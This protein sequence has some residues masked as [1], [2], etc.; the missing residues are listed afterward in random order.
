MNRH[1]TGQRS[2]LTGRAR[3]WIAGIATVAV[4][5]TVAVV[6]SGFDSRETPRAEPSVW[7]ARDA[8]QYAR[9]NTQT[10]EIDTVRKVSEPSGVV[11]RGADS[12]VLSHGNGQA[13]PVDAASPKDL[14]DDA[15]GVDETE[16]IPAPTGDETRAALPAV[17]GAEAAALPDGTRD[18]LG[19]GDHLL[20]RTESG[21]VYVGESV[22]SLQ[23]IDPLASGDTE[24][25]AFTADAAAIDA[26]GR[27]AVFSAGDATLWRYDA[28]AERF[29][30]SEEMLPESAAGIEQPELALVSG[31][32]V[33]L[34]P[35]KGRVFREGGAVQTVEFAG[36]PRLQW[37]GDG[38]GAGAGGGTAALI[39]DTSGLWRVPATGD[40]ERIVEA[41]GTPARP[42]FAERV[43]VAA[44]VD[45]TEGMLWR[46]GTDTASALTPL[47]FDAAAGSIGDP[48]PTFFTNGERTVL[49]EKRS[50]MLWTIPEGRLIPLSQWTISDPPKED[51]GTVVVEEVTE[52]VAPVAQDDAFGVRRGE[53]SQ[54][55][56]MLNDYD[57]NKRDVLTIVPE[58]LGESPLAAEFGTIELL[59]DAQSLMVRPAEGATGSATFSYRVT[60]GSLESQPAT[61]TLTVADDKVNTAPEWC[62][63]AGCQR[64]WAVPELAPGGTLVYPILEGWVDP[65]GD[66]MF[67][68]GVE[69]V[70]PEDPAR[71]MVTADGRLAVKHLD[72]NAGASEVMLRVLVR[73]ARGAEQ[74]RDLQVS[75]LPNALAR[76]TGVASTV[77][78]GE[79][80]ALDVLTRVSGGSGSF[81]VSDV[82]VVSGS[83]RVRAT[84][85]PAE[86]TV[87]ITAASP[88]QALLSVAV[89]D[90]G[91]GAELTGV[92]RI[93]A[94]PS[95][96]PLAL[97]PLRAFV[98]PSADSTV[99]ILNAIPG[100]SS[101]ALVVSSATVVDGQLRAEVIDHAKVRVAGSTADGGAGRIGAADIRVTEGDAQATG[102][103]TVFQVPESGQ[104]GAVAV[105][106]TATVRAGDVVDIRVLDNDVSAP[107][108][109]LVL[110]PEITGS[111]A[112]GELAFAS[113][114][115]LR[116]LA[117]EKAGTYQLSYTTY[118]ASSPES[119]DT[120]TVTVRVL[121]KGA[122]ADPVPRELTVRLAPGAVAEV[123]VPLS[124]VD[125][126]GDRVRLSGVTQGD[127]SHVAASITAGGNAIAVTASGE[128]EPGLHTVNYSVHDGFGGSGS[129]TLRVIIAEQLDTGAPVVSSD[130]V[131]V[132]LGATKPVVISPLD[133]DVDPA[134]GTLKILSV[135][136]NLPGGKAHPEYA[137]AAAR[138]DLSELTRGRIA[139]QAGPEPGTVSYKYTVQSRASSSTADGLILVQ[140]SDRV[141]TQAPAVTDTV[142]SVRDRADLAGSGV[143]VVTDK[144]RWAAGDV[145]AL[146]LSIW[147]GAKAGYQ[148]KG[149]RILGSYK[150]EGDLVPFKL[151][152]ADAAGTE[153]SSYGFLIV[154]PLDELRLTLRPG[155]EPLTVDENKSVDADVAA[156]VDTGAGDRVELRQGRFAVG[157]TGATCEATSIGRIRYTAG[158]EAPWSDVCVID[159]RLAGQS[160]WTSLPVPVTVV[161]RQPV[162]ALESLTRTVAPGASESIDLADMVRWEG[163]RTGDLSKLRFTVTGS[164]SQFTVTTS[165]ATVSVEAR[166]DA[167]PSNQQRLT[168]AVTGA[169][170]S[171]AP[172]VLRVGEV[173]RDTPRGA[174]VDL[175]CTVGSS[176]ATDV[177]GASGEYDPFAGKRGGGLK[178]DTVNAASCSV[179]NVRRAGD[180]GVAVSWPDNR[181][182][183]GQCTIG[184]TVRDAQG[185]TG[186]GSIELDAQGVPRSPASITATGATASSVT[187]TVAL[188]PQSA[189][190]AVS[191]VELVPSGGGGAGSCSVSGS[192]ATCTVN[193][194]T[195]G[196]ANQQ[197][198]FARAVN[199]VGASDQ[200]ANGAV[201]WAYAP[202]SA[203]T[204]EATPIRDKNNTSA[205]QGKVE[206]RISGSDAARRFLLRVD[207]A[208]PVEVGRKSVHVV[209][210]GKRNF[211]VIPEDPEMPP[212][213]AG[214][215]Q[216]AAGTASAVVGAAPQAGSA[217]IVPDS[218]GGGS[219]TVQFDGWGPNYASA[220]EYSFGLARD[221]AGR[222]RCSQASP[223]F[224]G[225]TRFAEYSGVMC[226]KS[227]FG[228]TTVQLGSVW[229]GGAPE[230]PSVSQGYLVAP[231]ASGSGRVR[232]YT[233]LVAQPEL[234]GTHGSARLYFSNG[235]VDA[236]STAPIGGGL[237]VKQ[238]VGDPS[239]GRC[240]AD[241]PVGPRDSGPTGVRIT[242]IGECVPATG[243]LAGLFQV[244]GTGPSAP[245]FTVDGQDLQLAW[246][247]TSWNPV[248]FTGAVCASP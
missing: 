69:M 238:C 56:V 173:P 64:E 103:L 163:N 81:T 223:E 157:R 89:T 194:L 85:R 230:A 237:T 188:N 106:D 46:S 58:S 23:L 128:A 187:L 126:D 201:T 229:V 142:M 21:R 75:V 213:Y 84:V 190:P 152:G 234:S 13:W 97:P 167:V 63:V 182:P 150:P 44:W 235:D 225:L 146:K 66:P 95:T 1:P 51:R 43:R 124:G 82:T 74:S 92:A 214:G 178:L 132:V 226:A 55:Q 172:L 37:S 20:V 233:R 137:R 86:G 8:G 67:L 208:A 195:P 61:V 123:R 33:L 127:D 34:D 121:P 189:H 164:S 154:P 243:D 62:P 204:V 48:E 108:E 5:V 156:L 236:L 101:R 210:P 52:Q 168:V 240:S 181:G 88:G 218:S 224:G 125:P 247:N 202:P 79:T 77:H 129:A 241:V 41:S 185:R 16:R 38:D 165:G 59:P 32:W 144:V 47:T 111:G 206:L 203:P 24:A 162:V 112:K 139:V 200:T 53:P 105:A 35:A 73:D 244:E 192:T 161:P 242:Q 149:G 91:T 221:G 215:S 42:S 148:V 104:G 3:G 228:S 71:A 158:A 175:R 90:V 115:T 180:R 141:G 9:V 40:P 36:S 27:V 130:Y 170:E 184:Y 17:E 232:E 147:E 183:G 186:E 143:D 25:G 93:T 65:E 11:Q 118:G 245:S 14:S 15:S 231:D 94:T 177:I 169:G 220:V 49:G 131:R 96:A 133:N 29:V 179:A 18:V 60:D 109:R 171:Q 159:V 119:S 30:G 45:Q 113:G 102:R 68:A 4:V 193:G 176:C 122:N 246:P 117:P 145:S 227:E 12:I 10:G 211:S 116:Y 174:T 98:R 135:E 198:Y 222:P 110:H 19:A 166:A 120:G 6:S 191:G 207:G 209:E 28:S 72:P 196:K 54:L 197:S 50:G 99:E 80:T 140:T 219:A 248:T 216:G 136:P 70:R 57:A 22:G 155:L 100:A 39:A 107:G 31:E 199:S 2:R 26:R 83:D 151:S 212:G 153:V 239:A 138:I 217:T 7:V 205:E 160:T 87:E 114:S 134:G 76:F 78:V